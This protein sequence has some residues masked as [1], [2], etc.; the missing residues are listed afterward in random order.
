MTAHILPKT[1]TPKLETREVIAIALSTTLG[2]EFGCAIT[3]GSWSY[4][5]QRSRTAGEDHELCYCDPVMDVAPQRYELRKL[6]NGWAVWDTETNAPAVV[7]GRW[8]TDMEMDDADDM[9][10]LLNRTQRK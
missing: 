9:T 3:S 4:S 10:D 6:S 7:D 8:Q 2:R 5:P 1:S